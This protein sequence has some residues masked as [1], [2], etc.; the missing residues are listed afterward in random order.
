M[1]K[2]LTTA[3][4]GGLAVLLVSS[5]PIQAQDSEPVPTDTTTTTIQATP[6]ILGRAQ[7]LARQ[8]AER[9]NGGL[10][11]YRAESSMYG[12]P[13]QSPYKENPDG[14]ITFTFTGR[15]PGVETPSYESVVTVSPDGERVTVDYNGAV[16][17][18][19]P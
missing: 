2:H 14:S 5:V 7:N 11:R 12:P 1:M 3:T 19:S 16:R 15:R 17:A 9:A 6:N 8:A 10:N 18:G 4:L 13:S